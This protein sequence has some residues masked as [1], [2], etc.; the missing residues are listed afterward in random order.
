VPTPL[1]GSVGGWI[2]RAG[3]ADFSPE[4][5]KF[6]TYGRGLDTTRLRVRTGFVPSYSTRDAFLEF[7]HERGLDHAFPKHRA[8][9][10]ERG[11]AHALGSST[12][13]EARLSARLREE[14]PSR[15]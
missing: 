7:V 6:L 5:I 3:V 9:A 12:L 13:A 4:Q 15:A 11:V 8:E 2:R 1:V 10:I 14:A